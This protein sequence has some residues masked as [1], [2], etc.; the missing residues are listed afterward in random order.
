MTCL[1]YDMHLSH[2]HLILSNADPQVQI[3]QHKDATMTLLEVQSGINR[4]KSVQIS[5]WTLILM[6]VIF[7]SR[8][9]PREEV[10]GDP[11]Y[12]SLSMKGMHHPSSLY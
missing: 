11:K 12:I 8:V 2:H 6:Q 10:N 1:K 7:S 5:K 4:V 3:S 9:N